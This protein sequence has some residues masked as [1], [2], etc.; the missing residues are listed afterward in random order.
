[1]A[2]R[3]LSHSV[4]ED[5]SDAA[6]FRRRVWV[7]FALCLALLVASPVF[8]AGSITVEFN[9]PYNLVVDSNVCSPS[10]YAPRIA[11]IGAG[12]CNYGDAALTDVVAS[13]GD[14]AAQTP[15]DYPDRDSATGA[16]DVAVTS[17]CLADSGIYE[18]THL[19]DTVDATRYIGDLDV[20]E[21]SWQ[22]WSF[23][24]PRRENPDTCGDPVWCAS[25]NP[26]DD[27]WLDFDVWATSAEGAAAD[28]TWTVTMRNEISASANKIYPNGGVWFNEPTTCQ[29]GE[30]VT[31]NGVNYEL[32]V[33]NKGFDNDG[34]GQPDYNAWLQPI[35]D[36]AWNPTCFRLVETSGQL[37]ISRPGGGGTD[38][39]DFEDQLYFT[40]LGQNNGIIGVVEYTF[41]CL[42]GACAVPLTPYQEAASGFDNEKFAGDYGRSTVTMQTEEPDTTLDKTVS[43]P[44]GSIAG[45]AEAGETLDYTLQVDNT[46]DISV[47]LPSL[48]MP[49]VLR[50]SIPTG[51][52]YAAGSAGSSV[53][54]CGVTILYSTNG[55]TSW[56]STEPATA[57]NVTDIQW[58]FQDPFP[59]GATG[60]VD[61]SVV[62]DNPYSGDPVILNTGYASFGDASPFAEDDAA[63]PVAGGNAIGDTVFRDD[64]SGGATA[65]NG[66]QGGTEPVISGIDLVL[67]WDVDGDGALDTDVDFLVATTT[68]GADGSGCSSTGNYCFD[69]LAAGDYLVMV[70]TSDVDASEPGYRLTTPTPNSPSDTRAVTG[71]GSGGDETR[72]T[73][74]FGFG[75]SLTIS[76]TTVGPDPAIDGELV[77]YTISVTNNR[78][79]S[80]ACTYDVWGSDYDVG[81]SDFVDSENAANVQGPDGLYARGGEGGGGDDLQIEEFLIAAQT[82]TITSVELL[83]PF[84]VDGTLSNDDLDWDIALV[85]GGTASGTV[86]SAT[87]NAFGTTEADADTLAIDVTTLTGG[88]WDFADFVTGNIIVAFDYKH[89]GGSDNV[90]LL[91]DSV[92]LRITTDETCGA[93][94]DNM[95]TVPLTDT[96]DADLLIFNTSSPAASGSM[97]SGTAPSQVGTLTWDL[98]PLLAGDTTTVTVTFIAQEQDSNAN[99]EPD[100]GGQPHVNTADV[101]SALFFDGGPVNDES[102]TASHTVT[103]TGSISGY[104]W[105]DSGGDPQIGADVN[106][107][108]FDSALGGG[109]GNELGIA[110]VTVQ[111]TGPGCAPC[112]TTTDASGNYEFTGLADGNFTVTVLPATLPGSTFTQYG[113]PDSPGAVC[114][115]CDNQTTTALV[116][117][118]ATDDGANF[119]YTNVDF[120]YDIPAVV[121]GSLWDD[122][123]GDGVEDPGEGPLVG[124]TVELDDGVCTLG[125]NCATAVTDANGDYRFEDVAAGTY[126]VVVD[127]TTGPIGT[128]TWNQTFDPDEAAPCV[129]CDDTRS[130]FTVLAGNVYGTYD[131]AYQ[132]V[133]LSDIGDTLYA[134]WDG[135]GVQDSGEEVI[136]NVTI[137]LYEDENGDG[138]RDCG[139]DNICGTSD[140]VD[141][142]RATTVTGADGTGCGGTGNYCFTNLPAGDW[143]VVV[144]ETDPDFTGAY[145]VLSQTQDPDEVGLC[146]TCDGSASVTTDG[147][148]DV[149]TVDMGYQPTGFSSIGDLVWNDA[150][151]DG[152]VGAGEAGLVNVSVTL[153]EDSNND[154]LIDAGD[155]LVASTV[156]DSNGN[157]AFYSLP[158]GNYLVDVDEGSASIPQDS[159]GNSYVLSGGSDPADVTL[160]A[161]ETYV[162]ADFGF[163][164]GGTIG[165]IVFRDDNGDGDQSVSEPGINN[166]TVALF[167]DNDDSGDFSVGDTLVD[168]QITANDATYGDGYYQFTGLE[169]GNYVVV[170]DTAD[171]DLPSSTVTADPDG[172]LDGETAIALSAAQNITFADFG[173]Q[174]PNVIGDY[175]WLDENGDGVQDAGEGGV[176]GVQVD[177]YEDLDGNGTFTFLATTTTDGDGLYSFGDLADGPY[178]VWVDQTGASFPTSDYAPTYE[179]D[180]GVCGT[181]DGQSAVINLAGGND[182]SADFGFQRLAD[183][184]IDKDTT[185]P[186]VNA[187]GQI[188]Y[189]V[190]ITNVGGTAATLAQI[191]DTLPDGAGTCSP[192]CFTY[193][194]TTTITLNDATETTPVA[195]T[196]G[197]KVLTFGQWTIQPA[198]SVIVEFV[199]DVAST[200][201]PG[202]YDNTAAAT[203]DSN[204]SGTNDGGDISVD[205]DGTAAQDADTPTGTDPEADEDVTVPNVQ[206][207]ITKASTIIAD[208]VNIGSVDPGETIEYLITV[209]NNGDETAN[210]VVITD[211]VPTGTSYDSGFGVSVTAP[212]DENGNY[213]EVFDVFPGGNDGSLNFAADWSAGGATAT[214][215][216]TL[217]G[218]RL[219]IARN[220]NPT[221]LVGDLSVYDSATLFFEFRR[222]FIDTADTLTV[223]LGGQTLTT[224]TGS[225]LTGGG[226]CLAD[227]GGSGTNQTDGSYL[228]LTCAVPASALVASATLSFNA[229]AYANSP[230]FERVFIDN[231]SLTV[232]PVRNAAGG[233][234]VGSAPSTLV[235]A[236]DGYD[237]QAGESMTVTWRVT[238]N[239]PLPV[240]QTSVDN[241][242]FATSTETPS[243]VNDTATD[244]IGGLASGSI[245][246]TVFDDDS[247]V[248]PNGVQD[249][250][251]PGL[252]NIRVELYD[253]GNNLVDVVLT[254]S[255]G[256]YQ[257]DALPD[258]NYRVVIVESTLPTSYAQTGDPDEVGVCSTCDSESTVAVA[259]GGSVTGVDFGYQYSTTPLPVTLSSFKASLGASGVVFD[260][261]TETETRNVG[262]FLFAEINGD[263]VQVNDDPVLSQAIDS[264]QP[265]SYRFETEGFDLVS[266]AFVMADVDTRGKLR[267][268]GPFPLGDSDVS[269]PPVHTPVAWGLIRQQHDAEVERRRG[270]WR[271]QAIPNVRLTV[272]EEGLYR[273]TFED[274]QGAGVDMSGVPLSQLA[275]SDRFGAVPIWIDGKGTFGPGEAIEFYGEA[276]ESLYTDTN[277]YTL[278]L[279][280]SSALRIGE[281]RTPPSRFGTATT[282]YRE[283]V[284][285]ENDV[286]YSF[287]A[288]GGDPWYDVWISAIYNPASLT[289]TLS[290]EGYEPAAGPAVLDLGLWGVTD[291]PE[292]PD[293][294]TVVSV[295]GTPVAAEIFDGGEI[296]DLLVELPDGV[297]VE[298]DND[299]RIDL[300]LDLGVPYDLVAL[301]SYAVTYPRR[302]AARAG[303][304]A[305]A[306]DPADSFAVS[307]LIGADP[308]VYRVGGESTQRLTRFEV[309]GAPGDYTV[310]FAGAPEPATYVVATPG[311]GLAPEI[312]PA[313]AVED[314][315]SG[316]ASYL[317]IVHPDFLG[318]GLDPLV[319]ARE[320]QG[321]TVQ[322][323]DVEQI[324]EN[325]SGGIVDPEAIRAYVA[326]AAA[327][328]GTEYVLLVGGDSYDYNDNLGLG[329]VGFVPS[330]YVVTHK[331]VKFA[332]ADPL[333]GDLD[334]D[335]VPDVA[336]GR[337]PVRTADELDAIVAKTLAYEEKDYGRTLLSA[338]DAYVASERVSFSNIS[339]DLLDGFEGWEID[340]ADI[341]VSGLAVARTQVLQSLNDGVAVAHYFGHSSFGLWSFQQ[342]FTAA[343]ARDLTNYGRPA[344]VIQWGC[345]NTYYV[346]PFADT[347][348]HQLMLNGDQG[349]AAVLGAGSLTQTE[350]DRALGE[351]FLPRAIE[352]GTTLGRALVEAK[353]ALSVVHPE[354][355]DV[356]AGWTILGDPALMIEPSEGQ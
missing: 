349:A 85:N 35:G 277:L 125:V 251:E 105:A 283:T 144:D 253:S 177:L 233:P 314:I 252:E 16:G 166:V 48:G 341:D 266:D 157:Y 339:Q 218:T 318:G 8:G 69:N 89:T 202:T 119:D 54:C 297:L 248:A 120:G 136:E 299:V 99:G 200:I 223:S 45:R 108:Q 293:H 278:R 191:T 98:G 39:V 294:H 88:T 139:S 206:L 26:N 209:T 31:T 10:T 323:V 254:D 63:I 124:V 216:P 204:L 21:C 312:Q 228:A 153:Y 207:A 183:L 60:T 19:G 309:T 152:L 180:A 264:T 257:F 174:P 171:P 126:T 350:S 158:A 211:A 116:I 154:G 167:L 326:Y 250:G 342:L 6:A 160:G 327:E 29:P 337:F 32:G 49:L 265:L 319:A 315:F 274:L 110:G 335:M 333:Y 52:S 131:F 281:D 272:P 57:S 188:T 194:S 111:L 308:A 165:D 61:F 18:L 164:P 282:I 306:G 184:E 128:G 271:Q 317:M 234:F 127:T 329:A 178:F 279:D 100:T 269:T 84:Y 141:A 286:Q 287:G 173:F 24:Y 249:V 355:L 310:T 12:F 256:A 185:T 356:I 179:S 117:D 244:P 263:W 197:D 150:D 336:V 96:Y 217:G 34:D 145:T 331:V 148:T 321:F 76:K 219:E 1:M 146:S 42:G 258:D 189:T 313:P 300:P 37:Q 66:A 340:R 210:D 176:S 270:G 182:F 151:G 159:Y 67:Y 298:G 95:Q 106:D 80:A 229:S 262:F 56:T 280:A 222:L 129:T 212:V 9:A 107:G 59:A 7:F 260:W 134:D 38:L 284:R 268:H 90:V 225:G 316:Q 73:V 46:G 195:P 161:N 295:N 168:N 5:V 94:S 302:L 33:V 198:G 273:V 109:A 122:A 43:E 83:L 231:V 292:S 53:A 181:C 172:T 55:G 224:L 138:I 334:G 62:V 79:A 81:I 82:G 325:L 255:S 291:W 36:D 304:L 113:D 115:T 190:R 3:D 267:F 205:D 132:E 22:Y 72:S 285:V 140:D 261:T 93:P 247:N 301:D 97:T 347:M 58:R 142:L 237:L 344:T 169:P 192:N 40:N 104:V 245:A 149:A 311:S 133:G 241:I 130:S 238:A 27:L 23:T 25:N 75:P 346:T 208:G 74:D 226:S 235:P 196:A 320:S 215:D 103:P 276:Y 354:M 332:P 290:V 236:S 156:T 303:H 343:Q 203:F 201:D 14:F 162:D 259:G 123:D 121:F 101:T 28:D 70:D 41:M 328:K 51:T 345:W 147:T 87:L 20:G 324:Y 230:S 114:G 78:P 118:L 68:S 64:G 187:G 275:L 92:G 242:A 170:V 352:P 307:G 91:L 155:A 30:T 2:H 330:L 227:P 71:L 289:R 288:S 13:I 65:N 17:S 163:G 243:P 86:S 77:T 213:G 137:Y 351:L 322:V 353:Q 296:P 4:S 47:G 112:T 175:V 186:D 221:R 232:F 214:T 50:D 15:G 199:V 44:G 239:N 348:G 102:D 11:T 240:G 305:F 193:A 246:G 338:S 143:I 220:D 135:D